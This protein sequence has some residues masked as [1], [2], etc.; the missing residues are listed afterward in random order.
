MSSNQEPNPSN[1]WRSQGHRF[2]G[3]GCKMQAPKARAILGRSGG[4]HPWKILKSR[5]PQMQFPAFSEWGFA[6]KDLTFED[7]T[8]SP[9]PPPQFLLGF[10]LFTE[11]VLQLTGG[12]EPPPPLPPPPLVYATGNNVHSD[13]ALNRCATN[14]KRCSI[15]LRFNGTLFVVFS[16]RF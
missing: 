14:Y 16:F 9:P 1:Q 7:C 11:V 13:W 2:G 8:W 12:A 10:H 6:E 15:P 4:M 5:V 3:G